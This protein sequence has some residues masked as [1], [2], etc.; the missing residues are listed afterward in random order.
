MQL[1]TD[2]VG[3]TLSG[4]YRL[5]ARLSGGHLGDVYGAEDELLNRPV[6]VKVLPHS[7][8]ID[9]QMVERF[10]EEAR[11]VARLA[12]A[13]AVA[14]YDWGSDAGTFYMVMEQVPSTDL[15]DLLVAKGSLAPAQAAHLMAQVCDALAAAHQRGLVHRA[16][17]PENILITEDGTVKVADFGIAA[18]APMEDVSS[19]GMTTAVRY[20]SP[21]QALGFEASATSDVWAAGAIFSEMLTGRPPLQGAGSELLEQRAHEEPVPPSH[22]DSS[23]SGD[24][25]TIVIKACQLDPAKRFFDASDMAHTIRRAAARSLPTAPSVEDLVTGI[26]SDFEIPATPSGPFVKESIRGKHG[27][28]RLKL[29]AGRIFISLLAVTVL[30][31]VG[32]QGFEFVFGAKEV[33]VPQ[34]GGLTV[35][36]ARA[37]ASSKGLE[38]TVAGRAVD[39]LSEEGEV[40]GQS[41]ASGRI[42]EGQSI[43]VVVSEGPPDVQVPKVTESPGTEARGELKAAN[44]EIGRVIYRYSSNADRGIVLKQLPSEGKLE[45]GSKIHLVISKGPPPVEVP[46]VQGTLAVDAMKELEKEGLNPRQIDEY[47]DSVDP[48]VVIRTEPVS[49]KTVHEGDEIKVFASLGPE[50]QEV[51]L[52]DLRNERTDDAVAE[53]SNMGLSANVVEACNKAK[54]VIDTDPIAGTTLREG[55][56]VTLQVC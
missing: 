22:F 18:V 33:A 2:L 4:R 12:H 47:S 39:I 6:A 19:S 55:D 36:E 25:D 14:V 31:F 9:E 37:R 49:G 42:E 7:M 34:L 48:G 44:F 20:M 30:T 8:A 52:P 13:N 32:V 43:G 51:T 50:F 5:L 1:M 15:R 21:E 10:K 16:L 27:A 35:D 46:R 26:S 11:S 54:R 38:M 24:L 53:L 45:W 3:R 40:I 29:R 41:P 23:I 28:P 56:S 17:K